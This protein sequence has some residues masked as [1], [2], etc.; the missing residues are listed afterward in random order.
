MP[1]ILIQRGRVDLYQDLIVTG[2]Q[3]FDLLELNDIGGAILG[4]CDGFH[5]QNVSIHGAKYKRGKAEGMVELWNNGMME[6]RGDAGCVMGD[7]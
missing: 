1:I 4:V 6:W 5:A 3:L 2:R 7:G